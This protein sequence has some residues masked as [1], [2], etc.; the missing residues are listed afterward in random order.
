MRVTILSVVALLL[1]VV[2]YGQ[3][4][5]QIRAD[6]VR[7]YNICDTA[8][9]ILENRT[10][11]V[12]GFLYNKGA[13]RTEFQKLKLQAL[14]TSRIAIVGQDTLDL[15]TLPGIGAGVDTIYASGNLVQFTKQG[16]VYS[17]RVLSPFLEVP[18][19]ANN[20]ITD[21]YGAT[22]TGFSAYNSPDMPPTSDQAQPHT[23]GGKQYYVGH[24]LRYGGIGYQMAVNWDSETYG[25][26]GAFLRT[27]DDTNPAGWGQWRELLFKDYAD[28]KY[29]LL[30][31]TY[32][33]SNLATSGE[34]QI[35][36][37]NILNVPS[38]QDNLTSVL[39]RGNTSAKTMAVHQVFTTGVPTVSLA[40]G[41]Y[42]SGINTEAEGVLTLRSKGLEIARW[43]NSMFNVIVPLK[44]SGN[45][46][47]HTGNDKD[48]LRNRGTISINDLDNVGGINGTYRVNAP[49]YS[50]N[51]LSFSNLGST[52]T[53]QLLASY[54]GIL[55]FRDKVD[56]NTWNAWK[57][58]WTDKNDGINSGLDAD[59]LRGK[60]SSPD[61]V[62]NTV[63]ERNS[64]GNIF[65]QYFNT[66]A[67]IETA[68]APVKLFGS[69]DNY[70]RAYDANAIKNFLN[71]PTAG[72]T[73]QSVS[74]RG[75]TTTSV[76]T[77][78][79]VQLG[80]GFNIN[81]DPTNVYLNINNGFGSMSIG[82]PNAVYAHFRTTLPNFYFDKGVYVNGAMHIYNTNGQ[83]DG[84]HL[85]LQAGD[86]SAIRFW[87][88]SP[89]YA[90]SM[91]TTTG[92]GRAN[93]S[94]ADNDFNMYFRMKE[95]NRGFVFIPGNDVAQV[96]IDNTGLTVKDWLRVRGQ[97]GLYFQDFGGGWQMTD[98]TWVRVYG[99]KSVYQANGKWRTDGILQVGSEGATM[100]V[101]TGGTPTIY[102]NTIYHAGNLLFSTVS[103]ANYLVQRDAS[104]NVYANG[105]YQSSKASLKKNIV[106]FSESALPLI[107]QVK[108]K[109][110]VYKDDKE[111]HVHTGIIADS[112]DWHF[113]TKAHDKF[114]T[115]SSLAI[116]MKAVQELSS[117]NQELKSENELLKKQ[118]MELM[119][120]MEELEKKMSK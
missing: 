88:G 37:G 98:N 99:D 78:P 49:G 10:Q 100:N 95:G 15:S 4:V 16:K 110:F 75:N 73:L 12:K 57:T 43:S 23:P 21:Y 117:Q 3:K 44:V 7:I 32:T 35:A 86:A 114:D 94:A 96:Q 51:L 90:I 97:S 101:P 69:N 24:A 119:K 26:Q 38:E 65:A 82:A 42:A 17:F 116:T 48:L 76:I 52:G 50:M 56:E 84:S 29:A 104:G 47:W 79:G 28:N 111:E 45:D 105:F 41:D 113:S 39:T 36:W 13:G 53:F 77:T 93:V 34:A 66:V 1:T 109:Q 8:E 112:T 31:N 54:T 19:G 64:N 92:S 68:N 61:A 22:L 87:N 120:K 71:L 74:S 80:T 106:D 30:S 107:N 72:E 89:Q 70:I 62:A 85:D 63:A 6:S 59:L 5:Y 33:K 58:I 27:K 108:I 67:P 18:V 103:T 60:I 55:Q 91:T 81:T 102:G 46:V 11:N 9:L 25:P 2:S 20:P 14:G 118:M 115:N 83:F 40:V